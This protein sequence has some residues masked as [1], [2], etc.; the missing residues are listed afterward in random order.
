MNDTARPFERK[1]FQ[2]CVQPPKLAE[3]QDFQKGMTS[4]LLQATKSIQSEPSSI[5]W[6]SRQLDAFIRKLQEEANRDALTSIGNRH[7]FF[8]RMDEL[9][10][11]KEMFISVISSV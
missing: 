4:A 5:L 6:H 3:Q 11:T 8:N 7:Y 10:E 1:D 2:V 9:L